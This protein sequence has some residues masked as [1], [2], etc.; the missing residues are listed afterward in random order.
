[1]RIGI[2]GA[3]DI[4][5][6]A[7]K[8]MMDNPQVEKISSVEFYSGKIMN[9]DTV[10]AVAGVGKVNAAVCAQTMILKYAPDYII[11]TGVAGGLSPE[12]EIGDIAVADKVCEHDMDTSPVGDELGFITGINKVYM[13]CDKDIVKLMYDAAN[14]V[15]DIKAISGTVASGDQFI[16]SDAQRNFIK[17]NFNAIAAEM[18][19]ASIGHVCTMNGVKFGVLR[20]ISD[21]ANSDSVVDFPTFTKMAVKNTV[22]IIKNMFEKLG[23]RK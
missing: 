20:A 16:A 15:D 17:E 21:G 13:E 19:G 7:L 5:V 14:A 4:E 23:D 2:I 11:N 3:M 12:L 22:E 8:E 1:M 10:V 6:Q 9:I 18:E